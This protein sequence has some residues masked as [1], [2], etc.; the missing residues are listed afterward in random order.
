MPRPL[1]LFRTVSLVGTLV[2]ASLAGCKS[3]D[4]AGGG[5]T[6]TGAA[7][8]G[9]TAVGA[10]ATG[11]APVVGMTDTARAGAGQPGDGARKATGPAT[12]SLAQQ[13]L[14]RADRGRIQGEGAAPVWV[15]V[16]SDFQCPY[17][18]I[19]HA[20]TY[21]T[22]VKDY[23]RTGKIRMA[24]LN[25]PLNSH[26]NA[27]P[28]AEAAMCASVQGMFWEMHD[29]I[30]TNQE[31]WTSMPNATP[32][33]DSLAV[34]KFALNPDQW[35]SCMST[36]ATAA[37]VQADFERL[38]SAGVE[39]TPSFF[40]GDRGISGAQPTDVFRAAIEQA[41]AKARGATAAKPRR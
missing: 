34:N 19:W 7:R 9:V 40:I 11:G 5:A 20:E 6:P 2:V 33:F 13:V 24:Y 37:L 25:Y 12:D 17:C 38:R 28:A 41:L 31:R 16:A 3:S 8:T 4:P 30:F 29:A 36:H 18:R 26:K 21:P 1:M 10:T 27:W 23:V 35:R 14:Q 15:I 32:L 39:S 22:L